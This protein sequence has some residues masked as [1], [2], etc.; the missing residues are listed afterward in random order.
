MLGIVI[1]NS[2]L[3]CGFVYCIE[4][5]AL[6]WHSQKRAPEIE[7]S[8]TEVGHRELIPDEQNS[9]GFPVLNLAKI[10]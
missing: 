4:F 10:L 9:F 3:N 8:D 7:I 1:C 2:Q 6:H 5:C